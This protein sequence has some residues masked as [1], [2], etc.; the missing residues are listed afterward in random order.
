M[1]MK[2]EYTKHINTYDPV[3]VAWNYDGKRIELAF[4]TPISALYSESLK[5]VVVEIYGE[6]R[7]NFYGVD[8]ALQGSEPIPTVE[9]YQFRGL[10]K[11]IES[12]TGISLLFHPLDETVGNQWRDTEQFE[13]GKSKQ[14][15][16]GRKLG[17]FR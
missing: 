1:T 13:M 16:I 5:N 9:H 6:N 2:I 8:G 11:S 3:A 15:R 14:N 10:N 4:E 12:E 17:I 7:L